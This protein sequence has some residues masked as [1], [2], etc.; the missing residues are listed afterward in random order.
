MFNC[1]QVSAYIHDITNIILLFLIW[2]FT[3]IYFHYKSVKYSIHIPFPRPKPIFYLTSQVI[4]EWS[5]PMR[6]DVTRFFSLAETILTWPETVDRKGTQPPSLNLSPPPHPHPAPHPLTTVAFSVSSLARSVISFLQSV[7]TWAGSWGAS[8]T[9]GTGARGAWFTE[10]IDGACRDKD[11]VWLHHFHKDQLQIMFLNSLW[12]GD[13]IW[14]H[15][16]TWNNAETIRPS[17]IYFNA[18]SFQ[19]WK[20][21]LK[22]T[23]LKMLSAKCWPFCSGFNMLY[24]FTVMLLHM[25]I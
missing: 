23:L 12:P 6:E 16:I 15:D 14:S 11:K 8:W 4:W 19:M 9:S 25:S 13:A 1:N 2:W 5:Q 18:I 20:F 3:F 24:S 7:H 22:D 21:H 10:I 17:G